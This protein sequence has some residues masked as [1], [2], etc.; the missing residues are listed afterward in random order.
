MGYDF[1]MGLDRPALIEVN[2]NAGGAM[3]N[4][5]LAPAQ[6]SCCALE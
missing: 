4:A 6:R 1:H 2:I 5:V 3:F